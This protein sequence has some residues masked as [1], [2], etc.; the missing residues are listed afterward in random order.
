MT[1]YVSCIST[2][3]HK[4]ILQDCFRKRKG[5]GRDAVGG[6]F[7]MSARIFQIEN[8]VGH[9]GQEE[10]GGGKISPVSP[11]LCG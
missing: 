9:K 6:R 8:D 1:L 4:T 3:A 2:T 11:A 7:G 10:T 5:N